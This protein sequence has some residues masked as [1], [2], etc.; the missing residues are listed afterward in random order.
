MTHSVVTVCDDNVD[1]NDNNG[2]KINNNKD[3]RPM[4]MPVIRRCE[5][6]R[7]TEWGGMRVQLNLE[8]GSR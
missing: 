8:G 2:S 5:C 6:S 3:S 4:T 1:N 7:L